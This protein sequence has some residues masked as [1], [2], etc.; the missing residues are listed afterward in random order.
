MYYQILLTDSYLRCGLQKAELTGTKFPIYSP[1]HLVT[2]VITSRA[3]APYHLR[4]KGIP[5][6]EKL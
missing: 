3:L 2:L 1:G 4:N 6:T 5:G